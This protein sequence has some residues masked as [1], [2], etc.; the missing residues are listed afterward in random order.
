M[1]WAPDHEDQLAAAAPDMGTLFNRQADNWRPLFTITDAA[2]ATRPRSSTGWSRARWDGAG[3][4]RYPGLVCYK[5]AG[6]GR[7]CHRVLVASWLA[8]Q[9][10]LVVPELGYECLAQGQRLLLPP[11]LALAPG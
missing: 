5:R 6:A 2:A 10:G 7:W 4:R 9:T 11:M 1:R 3:P 8:E